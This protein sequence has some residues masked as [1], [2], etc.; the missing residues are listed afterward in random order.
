MVKSGED[1]EPIGVVSPLNLRR[2]AQL[3]ALQQVKAHLVRHC[4][5][6]RA[7]E[8]LPVVGLDLTKWGFLTVQDPAICTRR[9]S[10][11]SVTAHARR[12]SSPR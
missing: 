12:S 10:Y 5:S 11:G 4:D 6:A 1:E 7:K 2:Y 3:E 9:T 8:Q